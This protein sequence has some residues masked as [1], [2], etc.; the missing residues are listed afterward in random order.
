YAT[1]RGTA[2]DITCFTVGSDGKLT[3]KQQVS[4]GGDGP[5]NFA[6]TPDG[7]FIFVAH[8]NS[9]NIVIFKRDLQS[10]WLT[11]TGKRIKVG[12]PV[13]LVFY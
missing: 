3:F 11:D 10:G 8:Q 6:I 13:C 9:D 12:A 7:Q 1:N 2:N 5:R 4:T